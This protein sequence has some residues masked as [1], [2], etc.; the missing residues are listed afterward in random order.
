MLFILADMYVFKKYL[1]ST[2]FLPGTDDIIMTKTDNFS[3]F[4][5]LTL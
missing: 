4:S 3:A 1:L 2:Y 5:G